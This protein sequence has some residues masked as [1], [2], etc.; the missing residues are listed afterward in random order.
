MKLEQ[1]TEFTHITI[2]ENKTFYTIYREYI[3]Y[4]TLTIRKR[5]K[6]AEYL[7]N[8]KKATLKECKY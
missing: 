6:Q 2:T 1:E 5:S 3:I 7:S 4:Y 8:A